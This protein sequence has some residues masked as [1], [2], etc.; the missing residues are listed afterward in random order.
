MACPRITAHHRSL[1]RDHQKAVSTGLPLVTCKALERSF[2]FSDVSYALE[3]IYK[4]DVKI[5]P[6]IMFHIPVFRSVMM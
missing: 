3:S 2:P 6:E 5:L 1:L 4:V